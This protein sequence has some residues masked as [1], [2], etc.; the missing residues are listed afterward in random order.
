[1]PAR[2]LRVD[3]DRG[4]LWL[5]LDRPDRGNALSQELLGELA[6]SAREL[7]EDVGCVVLFGSGANFCVGGDIDGFAAAAHPSEHLRR[8]AGLLHD[9]QSAL[10]DAAVPVVAGIQGW[11]AGAGMSLALTADM[12]VLTRTARMRAA[13]T[14]IGLSCDGG[15]SWTLPRTVGHARAMDLMLTNRVLEAEEALAWGLASRVVDE[16]D[17]TAELAGLARGLVDGPRQAS[18][19]ITT[20]ARKGPVRTLEQQL[21]AETDALAACG[22][23]ADS[24]EGIRAFVERRPARFGAAART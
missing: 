21:D 10:R 11:A 8:S 18:G 3:R 17:L 23:T 2:H 7:D 13:Y 9:F 1:M 19:A 12:I 24:R 5:R 20:L 16:D 4:A 14:G 6:A 22:A 15:M